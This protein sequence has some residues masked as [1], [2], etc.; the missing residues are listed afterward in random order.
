M[1]AARA[2]SPSRH[3]SLSKVKELRD[4]LG[5]TGLLSAK[6]AAEWG[7][8]GATLL[9]R[10]GELIMV[11]TEALF[12]HTDLLNSRQAAERL[13]LQPEFCGS[14]PASNVDFH[15]TCSSLQS[16]VEKREVLLCSRGGHVLVVSDDGGGQALV[17]EAFDKV[18]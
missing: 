15:R 6:A 3:N 17:Q 14:V 7:E 8:V 10:H 16:A 9:H 11:R 13:P 2:K 5:T 4:D 18:A 1:P 12:F